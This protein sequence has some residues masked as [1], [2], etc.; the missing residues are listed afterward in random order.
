[1]SIRVSS[2]QYPSLLVLLIFLSNDSGSY[3]FRLYTFERS[4]GWLDNDNGAVILSAIIKKFLLNSSSNRNIFMSK[5]I[6]MI[7]EFLW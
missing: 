2:I 4:C 1:M 3:P 5:V 7:K 6:S